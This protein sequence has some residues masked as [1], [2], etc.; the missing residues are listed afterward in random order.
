MV[1]L[2]TQLTIR[3]LLLIYNWEVKSIRPADTHVSELSRIWLTYFNWTFKYTTLTGS[4]SNIILSDGIHKIINLKRTNK[5]Q[6]VF[7]KETTLAVKL[8]ILKCGWTQRSGKLILQT[9]NWTELLDTDGTIPLKHNPNPAHLVL[10]SNMCKHSGM[11]WL[12]PQRSVSRYSHIWKYEMTRDSEIYPMHARV[13]LG[14]YLWL[15]FVCVK[16]RM[17]S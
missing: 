7:I 6:L 5:T 3:N 13:F 9:Q 1:I 8:I 14:V 10:T 2:K 4:G 17:V 11:A 16:F 15:Y 12:I